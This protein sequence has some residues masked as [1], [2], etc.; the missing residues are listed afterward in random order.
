LRSSERHQLKQ[1]QFATATMEKLS[2]AVDHR[3]PLLILGAVL[4][5]IAVLVIGGFYFQKSREQKASSMLGA[6]LKVYSAPIR[7]AGV[8]E[9]PGEPSFLSAAERARAATDKFVEVSQKYGSTD[10]GAMATYFLGLV[11]EELNDNAKAEEYFK[12]AAD[13]GN[14]DLAALAKSALASLYHETNRDQLAVDTYKQLI[15]KPT[16]SVPKS[17][18]QLALAE[19]YTANDPLQARK[20]YEEVQKD[21]SDNQIGS[22]AQAKLQEL[23]Q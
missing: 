8:P 9:T 2:W 10:S 20:L 22:L 16:N 6:A 14:R 15:E 18:A 17:S 5:V 19:I 4:V 7:P 11:S 23:K 21:N 1:D 12:K 3:N 13:S